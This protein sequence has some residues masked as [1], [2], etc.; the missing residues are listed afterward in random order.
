MRLKILPRTCPGG[1][2]C[3][4]YTHRQCRHLRLGNMDPV[5]A[6][7]SAAAGGGA[8]GSMPGFT[9]HLYR[10][11]QQLN[12]GPSWNPAATWIGGVVGNGPPAGATSIH[13][14]GGPNSGVETITF[15]GPVANPVLAIWSLGSRP[16]WKPASTSTPVN[17]SPSQAVVPMQ[18]S[19]AAAWSSTRPAPASPASRAMDSS[20]SSAPIPPS[21][22]PRRTSRTTTTSPSAKMTL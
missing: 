15:S 7:G 14:E 11:N 3:L 19:V 12:G 8:T 10:P 4:R 21:P 18:N 13:M 5:T 1:I 2:F 17:P 6:G 22:S 9:H 20:N 16:P